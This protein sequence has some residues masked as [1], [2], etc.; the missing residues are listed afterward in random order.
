[1]P[2]S[3]TQFG[4]GNK[5]NPGGRPKGFANRIKELC[6]DDYEQIARGL[7]L[8]A[9]GTDEEIRAFYGA[10]FKRSAKDRALAWKELRDSGPGRP[11][12]TLVHN[13]DAPAVTRVIHEEA[14][15][16]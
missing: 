3:D 16:A 5:A 14:E 7:Y 12:Q 11:A 2:S 4:P 9:K 10:T 1:M 15:D 8:I 6:G 13:G